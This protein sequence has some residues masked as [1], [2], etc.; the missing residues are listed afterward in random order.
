MK[1]IAHANVT[2]SIK[3]AQL[4]HQISM[5]KIAPV[6]VIFKFAQSVSQTSTIITVNVSVN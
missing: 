6:N 5:K 3:V 4:K 2:T 1:K